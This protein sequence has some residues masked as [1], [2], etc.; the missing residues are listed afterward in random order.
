MERCAS[1]Q[2]RPPAEVAGKLLAPGDGLG[3]YRGSRARGLRK[4]GTFS[5]HRLFTKALKANASEASYGQ[6][7]WVLGLLACCR[8]GAVMPHGQENSESWGRGKGRAPGLPPAARPQSGLKSSSW[9]QHT[10]DLV[11]RSFQFPK[12]MGKLL[13]SWCFYESNILFFGE[14]SH[15]S[16]IKHRQQ[17]LGV[18]ALASGGSQI[19]IIKTLIWLHS[20]TNSITKDLLM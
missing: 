9:K 10:D 20:V 7:N 14:I 15:G 2:P 1:P 3:P 12:Q 5:E 6:Q 17:L 4:D 13:T 19:S 8:R 16:D 11:L 18:P